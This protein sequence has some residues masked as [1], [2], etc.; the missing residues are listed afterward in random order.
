MALVACRECGKEMSARSASCPA[1]GAPGT[2]V[3][4]QRS[5]MNALGLLGVLAIVGLLLVIFLVGCSGGDS[6]A[7]P[8]ALR[9]SALAVVQGDA[10]TDTVLSTLPNAVVVVATANP[11]GLITLSVA[12][13]AGGIAGIPV[14][15][16]PISFRVVEEGCGQPFA[17]FAVTNAQ[18]Q[19]LE[20]WT[21]GQ[22]AGVCHMEAR[23]VDQVT[24]A[25][26]VFDTAVA[27]AEPVA[28]VSWHFDGSAA[29]PTPE[30]G[31][32]G[33]SFPAGKGF[34][35]AYFFTDR[36]NNGAATRMPDGGRDDRISIAFDSS[37]VR[38][39][40]VVGPAEAGA[41]HG[42]AAGAG[43]IY[44]TA[45]RAGV[46]TIAPTATL[47]PQIV[48]AGGQVTVTITP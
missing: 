2:L 26:I 47:S 5:E 8:N 7:P 20:R 6:I 31:P 15:N 48:K 25:P 14:P 22:R 46:T 3:E 37:L 39:D 1:C 44:F 10:Q 16:Q 29:L 19:A 18:G 12:G 30:N 45:L 21:L 34:T 9:P 43:W 23:A 28:A 36:Y 35:F 27:K 40:S 17:G 24:G 38:A 13:S 41:R 42:Y 32:A 11:S 4:R 33:L